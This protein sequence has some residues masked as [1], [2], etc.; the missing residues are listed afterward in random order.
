MPGSRNQK[1]EV[2]DA[3]PIDVETDL[4]KTFSGAFKGNSSGK[5]K[6]GFVEG[7]FIAGDCM[8]NWRDGDRLKGK[9]ILSYNNKRKEWGWKAFYVC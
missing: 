5:F 4:V 3:E 1:F 2:A 7:V 9:A 6:F 8:A